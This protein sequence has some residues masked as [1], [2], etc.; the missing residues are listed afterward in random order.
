[1]CGSAL[2]QLLYNVSIRFKLYTYTELSDCCM[3]DE[4]ES[5][6]ESESDDD[7]SIV[8]AC[9]WVWVW[10]SAMSVLRADSFLSPI[11]I[12]IRL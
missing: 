9:L 10:V 7:G 8:G 1:M 12:Y 3:C 4:S 6:S 5:E 2:H 11:V